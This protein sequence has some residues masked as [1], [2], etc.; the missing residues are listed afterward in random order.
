[1]SARILPWCALG[2]EMVLYVALSMPG[3][4][5]ACVL[6]TQALAPFLGCRLCSAVL[7]SCI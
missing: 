1:M 4:A 3:Y 5:M 2:L 6:V 7:A